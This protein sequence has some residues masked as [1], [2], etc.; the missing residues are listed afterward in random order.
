M[1]DED[2]FRFDLRG[3]EPELPAPDEE[4]KKRVNRLSQRMSFLTLLLPALLAIVIYM[5]YNDLA[6]RV[7]R[8]QSSELKS[9]EML[10]TDLDQ[11]VGALKDR[12]GGIEAALAKLD[13]VHQSLQMLQEE[14]RKSDA[15]L[16]K[17]AAVK[18]DKKQLEEAVG[19]NEAGLAALNKD[20]QGLAK[21]LQAMAPFREELGSVATL[22]NE[23]STLAA[24]LVKLESSLGKDL[25]GLAGYMERSKSDMERI[26]SELGS[27]QTRKLDREAMDLESLKTKRLYQMALDQE[28]SRID[29]TIGSLQRRLEQLERAFGT[30][31]ATPALP[32]L[33]GGI[34]EQPVE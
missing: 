5:A 22:R 16:E 18:A 33:T 32:P 20:V 7:T 13:A 30:K 11:T 14:L 26:K 31:S 34:K 2:R 27:L 19:R 8:S 21:D 28:I 9:V 24:R 4:L 15:A 23:L 6:L 25:T 29:K 17:I 12:L 10:A 3:E 1:A